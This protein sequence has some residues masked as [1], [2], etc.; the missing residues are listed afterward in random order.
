MRCWSGIKRYSGPA[1]RICS[2]P[3]SSEF[4]DVC[5]GCLRN[6]P[7][8]S[9]AKGFGIY[10]GALADA[11]HHYKFR[12]IRRLHA[13]LGRLMLDLELSGIDALVPVPLT[14]RKLRERGFNQSLLLARVISRNTGVP[15][16][17][18][19]LLKREGTLPQIG[20][21]AAARISNI[22]RAFSAE[23]RFDGMRV[24]LVDD[25]MTTGATARECSKELLKAGA[26]EVVVFVLA[27]ASAV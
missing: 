3:L 17:F 21:S 24:M 18:N 14:V 2:T 27:R 13:P 4:A 6:P 22:R 10:E 19:G 9:R 25:V 11:I 20:L 15:L 1:C 7:P 16:I 5:A 12:G 23:R 26:K 8:F